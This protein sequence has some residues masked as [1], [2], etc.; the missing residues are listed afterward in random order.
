MNKQTIDTLLGV[1]PEAREIN[2]EKHF[3]CRSPAWYTLMQ[4]NDFDS[5]LALL[6][7][8]GIR[9]Y[10]SPGKFNETEKS[11]FDMNSLCAS[12]GLLSYAVIKCIWIIYGTNAGRFTRAGVDCEWRLG[13]HDSQ[14]WILK[15]RN[16]NSHLE[17][18]FFWNSLFTTWKA[19]NKSSL[20]RHY[21]HALQ[22]PSGSWAD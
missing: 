17:K 10:S 14:S 5:S 19:I 16:F 6:A 9:N 11:T 2:M 3:E 7:L 18:S 20:T 1:L 12:A 13:W 21:Y 22:G 8:L 4:T 15:R